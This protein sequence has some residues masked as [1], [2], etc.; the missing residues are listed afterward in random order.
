METKKTPPPTTETPS[1]SPSDSTPPFFARNDGTADRCFFC[2][3][4]DPD[5]PPMLHPAILIPTPPVGQPI[6]GPKGK[7][8]VHWRW[9]MIKCCV[10]HARL[11]LTDMKDDELNAK[12]G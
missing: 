3:K 12:T 10:P 9:E 6:P 2:V 7:K 1:P 4:A 8:L 5:T 11:L